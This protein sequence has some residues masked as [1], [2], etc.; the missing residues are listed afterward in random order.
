[1]PSPFPGMDPYLERPSLWGNV[2]HNLIGEIQAVLSP[3]L[4]PKYYVRV[5]ERV[6]VSDDDDPGRAALIPDIKI[7][8]SGKGGGT[9]TEGVSEPRPI[10]VTTV[11]D[12]E[13]REAYLA[14]YDSG[15]HQIVTVIEVLSP[16]NKVHGARGRE[17]YE[18]KRKQIFAS[19]C[20]LVEIDLLRAGMPIQ[21]LE[22]LPEHQY[23]IH[24]SRAEK[25]PRAVLWPIRL[26]QRLP[27]ITI[28]L[29]A[30]DPEPAVDIQAAITATYDRGSYDLELDYTKDPEPPLPDEFKAWADQLLRERKLR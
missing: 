18:Q 6:Y 23:A 1:M 11:I 20:H 26:D 14:I 9:P 17:A 8:A 3:A 24:V 15:T 25:R 27:V 7:L 10:P 5:E 4:R 12:E 22:L 2:H 19:P 28:P 21:T 16:T 29:K 30:G 13:I